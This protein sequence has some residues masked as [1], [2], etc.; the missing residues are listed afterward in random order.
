MKM[1]RRW[2]STVLVVLIPAGVQAQDRGRGPV[3]LDLPAST[4]ALAM[5]DAFQLSGRSSDAIFYNPAL[6][7]QATGFGLAAQ[8]FG[9]QSTALTLSGATKWWKGA[10][11]LG[12]QTLSYSTDATTPQAIAP[13]QRDLLGGGATAVSE[14]VA[15][16]AYAQELFGV[17]WGVAGKLIEQRMAGSKDGV[18]AVDLGASITL[19]DITLGLSAQNLGPDM[20]VGVVETDLANRVTA[21][22]SLRRRPVGPLDLGASAS[23][24]R[25]EDGTVIPAFGGEV[26]WWPVTGRTFIGRIGVH[27]VADGTANEVTFGAAFV[28]DAISIEYAFQG[29]DNADGAHRFGVSWR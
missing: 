18:P 16:L 26:A 10:V 19:G 7:L 3:I 15:T 4:T 23:I 17:R 29:F 14:L 24:T 22:A 13:G 11:G 8:R 27:R 28:G 12:L 2:A 21:G 20:E 9:S 1:R 5:G 6:L 25:M